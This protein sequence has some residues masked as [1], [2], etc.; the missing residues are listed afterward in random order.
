M[1]QD[2]ARFETAKRKVKAIDLSFREPSLVTGRWVFIVWV[3]SVLLKG[4]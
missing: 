3:E 4:R 2:A 1:R